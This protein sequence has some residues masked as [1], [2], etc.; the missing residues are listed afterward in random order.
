[1]IESGGLY[2]LFGLVLLIFCVADKLLNIQKF[3]KIVLCHEISYMTFLLLL[4]LLLLLLLLLMALNL[5]A[6]L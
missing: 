5:I 1:M 4:S 6:R 3:Y 2:T